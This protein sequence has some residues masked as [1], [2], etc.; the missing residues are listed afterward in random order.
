MSIVLV[1]TVGVV[2]FF[3]HFRR[4][5]V[6]QVAHIIPFFVPREIS[7]PSSLYY[8]GFRI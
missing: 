8:K 3:V 2:V 7:C 1:K 6:F 4:P 5:S